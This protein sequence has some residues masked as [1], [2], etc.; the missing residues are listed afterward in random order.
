MEEQLTEDQINLCRETFSKADTD[1][2]GL[3][4]AYGLK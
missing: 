3:I 1:Q 4:D 2:D